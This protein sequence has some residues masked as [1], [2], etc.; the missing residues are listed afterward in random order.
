MEARIGWRD[1][2]SAKAVMAH[3]ALIAGAIVML[4][5]LAW[6]VSSSLKPNE[7]IFSD[8]S[9]WPREL[10]PQNYADGWKGIGVSFG[11]FFFNSFVI[12]ALSVIG[13]VISCSMAAY[14]FARLD[15]KFKRFWF[16]LMMMTLMLPLHVVLVPQYVLFRSFGWLDTI[17]PLTVPNFLATDAFFVFLMVQFIRGIPRDLDQ[18]AEIDGA[19]PWEIYWRIILPLSVPAIVT[20]AIFTFIWSWND[21]L[22]HL[23][24]LSSVEKYTVSLGL[25]L[26]LDAVGVSNWG[27][28]LAMS[29]LAVV[30]VFVIFL[31][32]Q[33]FLIHGIATT[34]MKG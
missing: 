25:R 22:S 15:F 19:S 3:L 10:R 24:Y 32:A 27:P 21:F 17:L 28:M 23:I 20:T 16:A 7:L 30:P 12:S 2:I 8:L 1:K 18:A 9:L 29:T 34:G 14:A 13:N 5:P 4:Y 26:F 11:R 6:M 33:R 31:V